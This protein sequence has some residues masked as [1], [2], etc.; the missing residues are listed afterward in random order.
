MDQSCPPISSRTGS[1]SLSH[2]HTVSSYTHTHTHTHR[3]HVLLDTVLVVQ[4]PL[5]C[6]VFNQGNRAAFFRPFP[7]WRHIVSAQFLL[8]NEQV[9]RAPSTSAAAAE[10]R[11]HI[12]VL[13]LYEGSIKALLGLY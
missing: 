8:Q 6:L 10:G 3:L 13:E 11:G 12:A 1:R 5:R 9:W 4:Q 7:Q 2:T